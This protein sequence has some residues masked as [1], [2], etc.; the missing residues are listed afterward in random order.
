MQT[1]EKLLAGAFATV[2]GVGWVLPAVWSTIRAPVVERE[3]TLKSLRRQLDTRED[4]EM[5]TQVAIRKIADWKKRALPEDALTAQRIYQVWLTRLA[6]EAGWSNLDVVP[7]RTRAVG[8]GT[9]VSVSVEGRATVAQMAK[10][11]ERFEQSGLLHSIE[12]SSVVA[13]TVDPGEQLEVALTATALSLPDGGPT[14]LPYAVFT[15][16]EDAGDATQVVAEPALGKVSVPFD[17]AWTDA[18]RRYVATVKKS[19]DAGRLTLDWKGETPSK[20]PSGAALV[21]EPLAESSDDNFWGLLAESSPFAIPRSKASPA[22]MVANTEK[23]DPPTVPEIAGETLYPGEEWSV[24]VTPTDPDGDD[25]AVAL[26]IETPPP[27]AFVSGRTLNFIPPKDANPG[28]VTINVV[29][30]DSR[31]AKTTRPVIM[32]VRT[33][34]ERTIRLVGSV[35]IDGQPAALFIDDATDER[36][37]RRPGDEFVAGRFKARVDAVRRTDVVF[38]SADVSEVLALGQR[39]NGRQPLPEASSGPADSA[40]PAPSP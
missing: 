30:T 22:A 9:S 23:N 39:L 40:E 16:A 28:Q 2:I 37:V 34:P 10:F 11:L 19:D 38:V 15:L 29:A 26:S 20:L 21:T 27:G 36:I 13:K 31:G 25:A 35:S 12:R 32:T 6:D 33:D 17:V 1:R 5:K 14:P 18:D 24:E 7:G 3:T 4:E 8:P